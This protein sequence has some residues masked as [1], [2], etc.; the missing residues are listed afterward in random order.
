MLAMHISNSYQITELPSSVSEGEAKNAMTQAIKARL[1][2]INPEETVGDN[3]LKAHTNVNASPREILEKA[4]RFL[5]AHYSELGI[6][7]RRPVIGPFPDTIIDEQNGKGFAESFARANVQSRTFL[8]NASITGSDQIETSVNQLAFESAYVHE[9][10]HLFGNVKATM[11][12]KLGAPHS[13]YEIKILEQGW[14]SSQKN[15]GVILEEFVATTLGHRYCLQNGGVYDLQTFFTVYKP[16][17]EIAK[18]YLGKLK[19]VH[20]ELLSLIPDELAGYISVSD[21]IKLENGKVCLPEIYHQMTFPQFSKGGE[22]LAI[23]TP[24]DG[25]CWALRKLAEEMYPTLSKEE[26]VK[27]F[28]DQC[29]KAHYTGEKEGVIKLF[30][31]TYG[32][33]FFQRL[34]SFKTGEIAGSWLVLFALASE[35]KNESKVIEIREQLL[36]VLDDRDKERAAHDAKISTLSNNLSQTPKVVIGSQHGGATVPGYGN[37]TF[38]RTP[39]KMGTEINFDPNRK[40]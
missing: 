22:P 30:Q 24:Y 32:E 26:A 15:E 16:A 34:M 40:K 10:G 4:A 6:E 12:E 19:G 28:E 8:A 23:P 17:S 2:T 38:G 25:F 35:V 29:I 36:A 1:D 9:L 27:L 14:G 37:S 33:K 39:G 11:T 7:V 21:E 18:T 3:F 5:V 20:E 31:D 13:H